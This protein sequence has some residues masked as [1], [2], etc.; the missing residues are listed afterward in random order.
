MT[1]PFWPRNI[2]RPSPRRVT[3]P[4]ASPPKSS[5]K[6]RCPTRPFRFPRARWPKPAA[7]R[8]DA[9]ASLQQ[10]FPFPGKRR[11]AAAAASSEA[12][13]ARAEVRALTLKL[14]E[15]VH[16][17]W[18]DLFLATQ[19]IQLTRESRDVLDSVRQTVE[20]RVAAD[21]ANQ[22]DQLRLANELTLI[23]RDLAEARE[24]R[25]TARAR[26]NSLLNRPAKASLPTPSTSPTPSLGSLDPL[27]ARAEKNHPE[28]AAAKERAQAFQHRLNRAELEKYPDISIGVSGASV[29]DSGLS[30]VANGRDQIFA[31]LGINIPLWQK[32]RRAMLREAREGMNETRA[33]LATTRSDLRYRVEE[34]W[35]RAKT[36]RDIIDLFET[37]L[38][39]NARQAYDLTLTTYSAGDAD[40]DA[41]IETWREQLTYQLQ[42]AR[43][44]AQ[45][46]KAT[47]TLK[48][49][50]GIE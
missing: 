19:T 37:K 20:S 40:F 32:P 13:A 43:H 15:Q 49:A 2:I 45:L 42:L 17:A 18:W 7:G 34:A 23:D 5:R 22:A 12:S 31:T 30:S 8:T 21:R 36:A 10:K 35:F 28:V 9:T 48:S 46:G 26:L 41:L 16:A 1:S 27:L 47:A 38:I 3:R 24:L 6:H 50:S 29:A 39:P 14:N 11:E 44:R 4:I 33:R 25:Q